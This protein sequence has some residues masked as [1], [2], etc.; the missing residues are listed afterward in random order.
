MKNKM[1][2]VIII[3]LCGVMG[4]ALL[5]GCGGDDGAAKSGSGSG[6]TSK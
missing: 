6:K 5:T 1:R 4:T 2:K 3:G